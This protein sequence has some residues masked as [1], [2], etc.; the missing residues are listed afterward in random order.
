[1]HAPKSEPSGSMG[2]FTNETN[3]DKHAFV[4]GAPTK[5]TDATQGT[6][7]A[8]TKS[9]DEPATVQVQSR[10]GSGTAK[11]QT[12]KDL[13]LTPV[14]LVHKASLAPNFSYDDILLQYTGF[15]FGI[16]TLAAG[17]A[18]KCSVLALRHWLDT[19]PRTEVERGINDLV[20]YKHPVLFYAV[21]RNCVDCV[22]LLVEYGCNVNAR[23][24]NGVPS[25]AFAI[26][27]TKFT[28]MNPTEVVKFL[29][30]FGADAYAIPRD[31]WMNYIETPY[32]KSSAEA[33][34]VVDLKA[35]WCTDLHR[36][37]LEST[38]NLSVRYFLDKASNLP[39]PT[40]RAM[41]L[42]KAHDCTALL[43]APYLIIGQR[44]A[45]KL[46]YK[47]FAHVAFNK[48]SPLVLT[49]AGL[50]G[51]G[52]TELA[53]QMGS[54]L[55]VPMT[56]IDCAQMR[57]DMGLFGSRSGYVGCDRGSQLNNF[58][59]DHSGQR[60]VV[61]MDEFDKTDKEVH[62][63]LLLLFDSGEYHDRRTN[64]PVDASKVLWIV[65][66]NLGDRLIERFY[67]DRLQGL[68]S[69]KRAE[70]EVK[71]CKKL[72]NALK[73][74]FRGAFGAPIAGRMKSIAP[75]FP[76]DKDEQAVVVHKFLM[77]FVEDVRQDIDTSPIVKRYPG[78][79]HL[80]IKNDGKLCQHLAEAY[81]Q[82]LG[83]R[84]L[85]SGIDDIRSEFF[86]DFIDTDELV[87]EDMNNGPLMK[88]IIQL[89]P[90]AGSGDDG[91]MESEV[92]VE[93]DGYQDYYKGQTAE[94][95]YENADY[96]DDVPD[97]EGLSESF[98][99][100]ADRNSRVVGKGNSK[101]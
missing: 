93:K 44:Y 66:T 23:D 29:L 6:S 53:K 51:H 58:L 55:G 99:K 15:P 22:K 42:A 40:A 64:K 79:V 3:Y 39:K 25:L 10:Q 91:Q 57:S 87:S 80:A 17:I 49:F 35:L 5:S 33:T 90:V 1:M 11:S 82:E 71:E 84:S 70:V 45:T 8:L 74:V 24:T 94:D 16:D 78:H 30:A 98:A 61:F 20:E 75:F 43:K 19:Y 76:F 41:Q 4:F 12:R 26:M 62:N 89:K 28:L 59:A 86:M 60:T 88:Y 27:R 54:L 31:M 72:I 34:N 100:L 63:S 13:R 2:S 9:N 21:E 37:L 38:L 65:A 14:F 7:Q 95:E 96:D 97:V 77:G 101:T 67:H 18:Q 48:S 47:V 73:A 50:S 68:E 36:K 69:G 52:K 92:A 32:A 83:A 56:V 81:I 85:T 46:V